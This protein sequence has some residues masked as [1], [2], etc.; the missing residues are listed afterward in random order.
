LKN[1]FESRFKRM[2]AKSGADVPFWERQ[3]PSTQHEALQEEQVTRKQVEEYLGNYFYDEAGNKL[4]QRISIR[5]LERAFRE[6]SREQQLKIV[7]LKMIDELY[8]SG[9][10]AFVNG[11]T[12]QAL[13][14][15][16]QIL[17]FDPKNPRAA[18][19]LQMAI[20]QRIQVEYGGNAGRAVTD[21]IIS[22]AEEAIERQQ[23]M[24]ALER[25]Q[26]T[27][28][29]VRRRAIVDFRTRALNFLS[30]GNYAESLK[31]WNKLLNVDPGNAS[32]LIFREICEQKLKDRGR[33]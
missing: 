18:I 29:Q 28:V 21:K 1:P 33:R 17:D 31:E 23:T 26:E 13:E 3:R 11:D 10:K 30:E 14:N 19:L 9:T 7:E 5:D 4:S 16:T 22:A 20:R 24:L 25:E 12:R 27:Q 8:T 15:W 6:L 2:V 32:A